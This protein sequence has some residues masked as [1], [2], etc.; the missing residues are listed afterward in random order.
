MAGAPENFDRDTKQ[1]F[2]GSARIAL[3]TQPGFTRHVF[4]EEA[5]KAA[6]LESELDRRSRRRLMSLAASAEWK[7][8]SEPPQ[9]ENLQA[10]ACHHWQP[11]RPVDARLIELT[12]KD[13]AR[14]SPIVNRVSHWF[15]VRVR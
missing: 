11:N 12:D 4:G 9:Q 10:A 8:L 7:P 5:K 2:D 15:A 1:A 3:D 14:F 6:R 13:T